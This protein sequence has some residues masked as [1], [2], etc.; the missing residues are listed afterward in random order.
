MRV[1]KYQRYIPNDGKHEPHYYYHN[2]TRWEG[3]YDKGPEFDD[4]SDSDLTNNTNEIL[5]IKQEIDNQ[6]KKKRYCG[7]NFNWK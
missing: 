6:N 5:N 1:H 3:C 2:G 4:E 7:S